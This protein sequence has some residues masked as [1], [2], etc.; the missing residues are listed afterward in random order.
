MKTPCCGKVYCEECLHSHL[1]ENNFICP[2][3]S[4]RISSVDKL[5]IDKPMR[6]RVGDYIDKIIKET[7]E[8]EESVLK[9][10]DTQNQVSQ[11]KLK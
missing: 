6:T 3:C 10:M 1:L 2:N 7:R 11:Y 4:K 5:L 9:A 8:A